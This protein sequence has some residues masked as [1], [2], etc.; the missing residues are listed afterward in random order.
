METVCFC[1]KGDSDIFSAICPKSIFGPQWGKRIAHRA[2]N[3]DLDLC[4]DDPLPYVENIC[5]CGYE[6]LELWDSKRTSRK[7]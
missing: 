4:A 1:R 5:I 3:G 7:M 2:P 6:V